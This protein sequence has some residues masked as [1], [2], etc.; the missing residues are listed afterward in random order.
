[1]LP[2]MDPVSWMTNKYNQLGPGKSKSLASYL[3]KG[4]YMEGQR[5]TVT[6]NE[7]QQPFLNT[8]ANSLSP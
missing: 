5:K 7:S 8:I 4:V 1:V 2:H 6:K 3:F